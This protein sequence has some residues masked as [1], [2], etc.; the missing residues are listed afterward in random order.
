[1]DRKE[2]LILGLPW[3]RTVILYDLII[4][5]LL[6]VKFSKYIFTNWNMERVR[7]TDMNM[8]MGT[9]TGADINKDVDIYI[10]IEM[11]MVTDNGHGHGHCK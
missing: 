5:Y 6:F 7:D 2:P 4:N 3:S 11:D 8:D 9:N 1:M 10:D